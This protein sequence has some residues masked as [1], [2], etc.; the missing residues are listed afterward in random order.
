MLFS[1]SLSD[2]SFELQLFIF[3]TYKFT[4]SSINPSFKENYSEI[5]KYIKFTN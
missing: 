2:I 1:I 5:S 3:N 4:N